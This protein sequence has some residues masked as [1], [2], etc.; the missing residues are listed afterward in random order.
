M[1]SLKMKK[2]WNSADE[3][4]DT[5]TI[6]QGADSADEDALYPTRA[7]LFHRHCVG[8]R[9]QY[10]GNNIPEIHHTGEPPP[11]YSGGEANTERRPL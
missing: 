6:N 1:R 3:G 9:G 2:A 5:G 7:E 11:Y 8:N 4:Y 10:T